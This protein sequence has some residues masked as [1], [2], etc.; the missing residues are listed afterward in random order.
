MPCCIAGIIGA[1][2]LIVLL[3][4]R[5]IV[6]FVYLFHESLVPVFAEASDYRTFKEFV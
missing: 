1:S 5:L 3:T 6:L 4:Y 2:L